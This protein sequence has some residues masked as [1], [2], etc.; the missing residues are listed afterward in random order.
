MGSSFLDQQPMRAVP[1]RTKASGRQNLKMA[2]PETMIRAEGCSVAAVPDSRLS[3]ETHRAGSCSAMQ[4]ADSGGLCACKVGG[5]VVTVRALPSPHSGTVR[6][7]KPARTRLLIAAVVLVAL[8]AAVLFWQR[9]PNTSVLFQQ[10]VAALT[11]GDVGTAEQIQ[12]QLARNP[13]AT[14][15]AAVLRGGLQANTGQY[16]KALETLDPSLATGEYREPVLLWVGESFLGL[17]DMG[18]AEVCL[19]D[20]VREFP[21]N[22]HAV[23]LLAIVYHDLGAMHPALKQLEQLARLAPKDYRVPRMCG[24]IYLDFEQYDTC[25]NHLRRALELNPPNQVRTEIVVEMARALRKQLKH[26]EALNELYLVDETAE[27]LGEIALNQ[28]GQGDVKG[29]T[30]SLQRGKELGRSSPQLLEAESQILYEKKQYNAALVVLRRLLAAQPHEHS[31]QYKIALALK[32]T[33]AEAEA[34]AALQRF[35]QMTELRKKLTEL[36][37]KANANPYDEAIRLQ[38]AEVCDK[39][40]RKDLAADWRQAATAARESGRSSLKP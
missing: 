15:A 13:E 9:S 33:G 35:E 23:R 6:P 24:S 8:V 36:N 28:I 39:L 27:S 10:G 12:A 16:A 3:R 4:P 37:D 11:R 40:G 2:L 19:R 29:A 21:D 18:R 38:L 17:K 26:A 1:S 31:I 25:V 5:E 30:E 7:M 22:E 20:V 14:D 34:A 32:E